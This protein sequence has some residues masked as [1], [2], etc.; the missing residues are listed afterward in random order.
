MVVANRVPLRC[1]DIDGS[2]RRSNGARSS[3][4][5]PRGSATDH[6]CAALARAGHA[7]AGGRAIMG[8]LPVERRIDEQVM[9]SPSAVFDSHSRIVTYH[10]PVQM[11]TVMGPQASLAPEAVVA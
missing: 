11:E 5:P 8:R 9:R 6:E 4:P 1:A 7:R 2:R 3:S 10:E